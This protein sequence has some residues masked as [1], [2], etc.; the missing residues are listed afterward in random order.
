MNKREFT[1]TMTGGY[2]RLEPTTDAARGYINGYR[3]GIEYPTNGKKP[4]LDGGVVVKVAGK[5]INGGWYSYNYAVADTDWLDA[6]TFKITDRRY[7]PADTS[8]LE[9]PALE[10]VPQEENWYDYD[11][12]KAIALPPVGVE[13]EFLYRFG[14]SEK[15]SRGQIRYVGVDLFVEYDGNEE[16]AHFMENASFRPLDHN[17]KAEAEK[18]RVVDAAF[19]ALTEFRTANQVLGELYDAGYLKLPTK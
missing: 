5:F 6:T 13:C 19:A 10:P 1:K 12:Q 18:K 9:T 16:K 4:D 8:Y 7:K 15:W 17:R 3:Y 2:E 14:S 11:N